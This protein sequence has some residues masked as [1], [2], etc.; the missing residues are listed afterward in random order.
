MNRP[1]NTHANS[2]EPRRP[3]IA[4]AMLWCATAVLAAIAGLAAQNA[5]S[6]ASRW[7]T[8]L[9]ALDPLRPMDYL[10]LGEEVADAATAE[11]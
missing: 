4:S 10:E 6:A 8:R 3:H 1:R 11:E 2:Q 7:D 5:P 9:A